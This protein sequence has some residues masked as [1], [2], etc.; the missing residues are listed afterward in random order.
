MKSIDIWPWNF[1][2]Y[3]LERFYD[4]IGKLTTFCVTVTAL[5][6]SLFSRSK[7][8]TLWSEE[9]C[10]FSDNLVSSWNK[11]TFRSN[12]IYPMQKII[13]KALFER[14]MCKFKLLSY[15]PTSL[16]TKVTCR[17]WRFVSDTWSMEQQATFGRSLSLELHLSG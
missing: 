5:V 11:V 14:G 9:L 17:V 3:T 4:Q 16:H 12:Y 7:T 2:K 10:F 15:S 6:S 13:F 1:A 8:E